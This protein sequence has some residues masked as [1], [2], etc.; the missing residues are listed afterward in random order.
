MPVLETLRS[1]RLSLVISRGGDVPVDFFE[2]FVVDVTGDDL[3]EGLL[4]TLVSRGGDGPTET[5]C[6]TISCGGDFL[7]ISR[8]GVVRGVAGI[9]LGGDGPTAVL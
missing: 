6:R 4:D 7:E 3:T 2:K 5:L 8:C 9:S 1:V